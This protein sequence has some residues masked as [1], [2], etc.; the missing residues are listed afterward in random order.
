[1]KKHLLLLLACLSIFGY[2]ATA[3]IGLK[4]S[5]LSPRGDLGPI[6][7]KGAAYE[8]FYVTD[9]Y[10]GRLRARL[11]FFHTSLEPR[12]DT[13]PAYVVK[14]SNTILPGFAVYDK[15]SMNCIYIDQ[16]LRL[17]NVRNF[18]AY[19]GLGI[20]FGLSRSAYGRTIETL[21]IESNTLNNKIGGIRSNVQAV[22]TIGSHV[23]VFAE[24]MHNAIVV[25]D[26]SA[27]Y[28]HRTYGIGLNYR[29]KSN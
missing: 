20:M 9:Y 14:G 5:L 16:S 10:K 28:A 12:L 22:Y 11:G 29:F 2:S 15:L 1:M 17:L 26:W 21:L 4:A 7:K 24:A 23:Q 25:T 18:S 27:S 8:I 3:Q 13:F 19:A 6:Y